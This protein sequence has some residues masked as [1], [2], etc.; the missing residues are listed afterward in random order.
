MY[1]Y[2]KKHLQYK[3][4]FWNMLWFLKNVQLEYLLKSSALV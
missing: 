2:N 3:L 4:Y 1:T